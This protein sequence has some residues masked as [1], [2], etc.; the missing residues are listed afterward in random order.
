MA[1]IEEQLAELD[2]NDFNIA[3]L[4][5]NEADVI[6]FMHNIIEELY[7]CM[8][9]FNPEI[10]LEGLR[11]DVDID[12]DVIHRLDKVLAR[13]AELMHSSLP[14]L[15]GSDRQTETYRDLVKNMWNCVVCGGLYGI[16]QVECSQCKVFR[17]LET[18]ENLL[19]RPDKVS[20]D[21]IEALKL[22]RK[23]EKQI[24]LDLE[25]NGEESPN[26]GSDPLK[27]KPGSKGA[28][29]PWY[30]ISSD[31]LFKWKCFVTNKISKAVNQ[32]I[33]HEINQSP[34][35][36]IGILPPGSITNYRL[37]EQDGV[38]MN[39]TMFGGGDSSKSK[40]QNTSADS[41]GNKVTPEIREDLVV[42]LDYK[43][44]KREV[45]SKFIKIYSGGPPIVRDKPYIYS[46]ALEDMIVYE[47]P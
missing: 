26:K 29:D 24:I 35:S 30:M 19:H 34:N 20:N 37:F 13:S 8:A 3:S 7:G 5:E 16:K 2:S 11:I 12:N 18:F 25:L 44:V 14:P 46:V 43:T 42:E 28:K 40:N 36:R 9:K 41:K 27:L 45:W 6:A 32:N 22:R 1:S 15:D 31:W 47:S 39:T 17:P 4:E 10:N 21:E 23:I 38:L 33:L